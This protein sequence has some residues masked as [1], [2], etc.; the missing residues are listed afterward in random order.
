M[1]WSVYSEILIGWVQLA[2]TVAVENVEQ[3]SDCFVDAEVY[4]CS[5]GNL[6]T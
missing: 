5:L 6:S 2:M 3:Y 4:P 1:V